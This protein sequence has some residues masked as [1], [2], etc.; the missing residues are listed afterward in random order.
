MT[1]AGDGTFRLLFE[2][3]PLSMWVYDVATLAFLEVNAAAVEHYGY[4]RDEFLTM[5]VVDL[6]LPEEGSRMREAVARL[7]QAAPS[8]IRP[9][10]ATWKHRCKNGRVID[11]DIVAHDLSFG[12]RRAALVVAHDVTSLKAAQAS[13]ARSGRRLSVLHEIDRGMIAAEAPVA[14]AEAA[15][16][17]LRDLLDVPRAIV[18]LFDLEA[19]EV[20]WLA[21]IGRRR[22][23]LGPGVRYPLKLVGDVEALRRGETQVIDVDAMP[24]GPETT[25]LLASGVHVYMVVPMLARGELIGAL[26]FGGARGQ[27][28][29]EQVEI[30]REAA[31]QL[32]IAITQARLAEEVKRHSEQLEQRVRERTHELAEAKAEADRA[33]RAKSD[34]LSRMSHEL[35]TPLNAILGFGQLLQMQADGGHDRESVEQILKGGRHLLE[36]INEVLDISRIEAGRLPLSQEPVQIGEAV[37]RVLDLARPLA[38]ERRIHVQIAGAALHHRYVLADTQRLQQVLL[39]LVSNGIKY[40]RDGGRLVVGCH[41]AATGRIRLTVADTG[42]GIPA[43]R[44]AR[45]FTPFDRLGAETSPVEGTGLGLA[46]SRRLVEAM[47]GTI[48]LDDAE[49]GGSL[50]WIELAETTSPDA[51]AGLATAPPPVAEGRRLRGTILYV[52][53]NASNLRLVERLLQHAG[54]RRLV[55]T[56]DSRTVLELYR[57]LQPDLILLDLMMPHVDGLAVLAQ[58]RAEIPETAYVPVLVLTADVT[59][60]AR[61]KALA[62]GAHDFLTKPFETFEALLR[63]SNLLATRRLHLALEEHNRALEETVR[64]RTERLLQSE[65]VATMGSLLAGVAHELNNPLTVLSAQAQLL[66]ETQDPALTARAAK[67]RQAAER[68]VR[69]V[70]NFLAFARQRAPERS[71]TLLGDVVGATLELLAYELRVDG[72]EVTVDLAPDLPVLWVDPHQLHQVLV[73]LVANAHHALRRHPPPRRVAVV[74]RHDAAR[75]RVRLDIADLR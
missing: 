31:A 47:G 5:K 22:V 44:R 40:N 25:A 73:N 1:A 72:V 13:L 74:A 12:G 28:S 38:A 39:N 10:D 36:L 8:A 67:I 41:E 53:D 18:N 32:A 6:F 33:N 64:Q 58:L 19:G 52:E 50:F 43:E 62:A 55:S 56:T 37:T 7:P 71:P 30:A 29:D 57:R 16:R 17:P 27:F 3:N 2:H 21:A 46:L 20:E 23:R 63:I 68:C 34:F 69:I 42:A 75:G 61:R 45:L 15:L 14:I 48:G 54:Y 11:V 9:Y 51:R 70:R 24:D 66:G 59:L 60:E 65:K 49:A 26:S 35:R 4:S